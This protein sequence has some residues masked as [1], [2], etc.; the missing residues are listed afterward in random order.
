[1]FNDI[2]AYLLVS[3]VCVTG[4]TETINSSDLYLRMYKKCQILLVKYKKAPTQEKKILEEQS[5]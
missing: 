3:Q 4:G 2:L 5:Q 1:M